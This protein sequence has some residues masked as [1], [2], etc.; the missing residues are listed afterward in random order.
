MPDGGQTKEQLRTRPEVYASGR[1]FVRPQYAKTTP[2]PTCENLVAHCPPRAKNLSKPKNRLQTREK[3]LLLQTGFHI[4]YTF[5]EKELEHFWKVWY[6]VTILVR[7]KQAYASRVVKYLFY[8]LKGVI[9]YDDA[10][11]LFRYL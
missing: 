2:P 4:S 1:V 8:I 6:I 9:H 5:C 10:C 11:K 3:V 7:I